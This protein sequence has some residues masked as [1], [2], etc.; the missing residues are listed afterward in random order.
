MTT[1]PVPPYPAPDNRKLSIII[2]QAMERVDA[3]ETDVRGAIRHAAVQAWL[4][5][6]L[7]GEACDR[8][9]RDD[10]RWQ[11]LPYPDDV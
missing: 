4:E 10:H 1:L 7:E 2:G 9:C 5:G 11:Q 3:G 6:H 8:A